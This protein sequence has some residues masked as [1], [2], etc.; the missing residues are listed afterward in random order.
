[1]IAKHAI[2]VIFL[3][4]MW[5]FDLKSE[6][7]VL[8]YKM[9]AYLTLEQFPS[10]LWMSMWRMS[11]C[12]NKTLSSPKLTWVYCD[13]KKLCLHILFKSYLGSYTKDLAWSFWSWL[14][15][16]SHLGSWRMYRILQKIL[17]NPN[18]LGSCVEFIARSFQTVHL[19]HPLKTASLAVLSTKF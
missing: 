10:F 18:S 12:T 4:G 8:Q 3:Q 1:M 13:I 17:Y 14:E 7:W 6:V 16:G 9:S 2:L 5:W 11:V 19:H 15:I